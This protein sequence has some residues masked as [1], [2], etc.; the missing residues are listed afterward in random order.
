MFMLNTL[1][2]ICYS[3]LKLDN[4]SV[5]MITLLASTKRFYFTLPV[6]TDVYIFPLDDCHGTSNLLSSGYTSVEFESTTGEISYGMGPDGIEGGAIMFDGSEFSYIQIES[7]E[8][9]LDTIFDF[10][11]SFHMYAMESGTD[12]CLF[13]Y[14]GEDGDGI[15][16]AAYLRQNSYLSFDITRRGQTTMETFVVS[17]TILMNQW[18]Q[19]SFTYTFSDFSARIYING[20]LDA[21]APLVEP[22]VLATRGALRLGAFGAE[23]FV[24]KLACLAVDDEVVDPADPADCTLRKFSTQYDSQT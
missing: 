6:D 12:G 22:V 11:I 24:G 16:I 17:S 8:N 18:Y 3:D 20:A 10:T 7:L 21:S 5:K 13:R 9:R 1:T 14:M 2:L 15:G 4:D 23:R 19:V